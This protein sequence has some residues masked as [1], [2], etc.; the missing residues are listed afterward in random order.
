MKKLLIFGIVVVLISVNFHPNSIGESNLSGKIIY[1]DDDGDGDYTSI[2]DAIDNASEGDTILVY[3]GLYSK[4]VI[5]NDNY[6]QSRK[7]ITLRGIPNELGEGNDTGKPVIDGIKPWSTV[8]DLW[9][10]ENCVIQ[11]FEIINGS[12]GILVCD[13]WNNT[14]ADNT[15]SSCTF[16][17][18]LDNFLPTFYACNNVVENN[19][20]YNCSYGVGIEYAFDNIIRGNRIENCSDYGI[21]IDVWPHE[22]N[23]TKNDVLN[24]YF[25]NNGR[26]S[27][28]G[29]PQGGGILLGWIHMNSRIEGNHFEG[30]IWSITIIGLIKSSIKY[31]NFIQSKETHVTFGLSIFNS[32]RDNYWDDWDGRGPYILKGGL[33]FYIPWINVDWHPSKEPYNI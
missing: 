22:L 24:N 8:I 17:V 23:R 11:G 28:F 33:L 3:S 18:E 6:T 26:Y 19:N 5:R 21:T 12:E 32:W 14:I 9:E 4:I 31:N 30:N 27:I 1:V 16:G 15:I 13:S 2:Q 25:I 29:D 20:I 10:A 7:G